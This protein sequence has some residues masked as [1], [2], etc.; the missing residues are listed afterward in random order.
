[1]WVRSGGTLSFVETMDWNILDRAPRKSSGRRQLEEGCLR[2]TA[3]RAEPWEKDVRRNNTIH[4]VF[5]ILIPEGL[6]T[7]KSMGRSDAARKK[8]IGFK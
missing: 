4:R 3:S 6:P 5:L 8:R 2:P 1:M 7:E